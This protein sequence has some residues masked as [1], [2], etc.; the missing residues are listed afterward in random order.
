MGYG[1]QERSS[2]PGKGSRF[3][4][5]SRPVLGPNQPPVQWVPQTFSPREKRPGRELTTHIHPVP[6]QRMVEL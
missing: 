6:K 5:A 1:L 3:L 2:N 4:T